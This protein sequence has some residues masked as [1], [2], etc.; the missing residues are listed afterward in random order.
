MKHLVLKTQAKQEMIDITE[1]LQRALRELGANN[2]VAVLF[3]P[4]TTAAITINENADPAVKEDILT[5]LGKLVP[6]GAYYKHAEGNAHAHIKASLIGHS[7]TIPI[8]EGKLQLGTWQGV[9]F[10]EFDGPRTRELWL[11]VCAP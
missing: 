5:A 6:A 9:L 10:C 3:V 8:Q 1:R 2:G 4:H 11:T 7:V